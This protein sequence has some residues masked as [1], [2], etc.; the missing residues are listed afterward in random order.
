MELFCCRG[1]RIARNIGVSY[2]K[3]TTL[4]R[5]VEG[6]DRLYSMLLRSWTGVLIKMLIFCTFPHVCTLRA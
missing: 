3:S 2:A 6:T 4:P 1:D 5:D